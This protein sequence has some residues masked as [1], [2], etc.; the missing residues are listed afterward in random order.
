MSV[1]DRPDPILRVT[2]GSPIYT[3]DGQKI[4]TVKER[5][6]NAFK[7]GTALWQRDYWLGADA[8][9]VAVPDGPVT[10]RVDKAHLAEHRLQDPPSAT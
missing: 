10:L 8:I 2:V 9:G 7:V 6:G 4:G 1:V 3:D 5:R